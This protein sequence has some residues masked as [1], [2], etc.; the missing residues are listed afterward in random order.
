MNKEMVRE[1]FEYRDDQLYWRSSGKGRSNIS[2]PA[3]VV[4]PRGHR[5]IEVKGK[6]YKAHRLIWLYVNG[7]F[8]DNHIDHID[9]DPSNNRIEN[10]RDVTR[11]ENNK[12][13]RK[14]RTNKSGH[15]GVCWH[16]ASDKWRAH[17]KVDGV[18]KHLGL[19]NVLEDAVAA[20]QAAS[21]KHGFHANHG[22]D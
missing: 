16:K 9:G 4:R 22:R 6:E 14:P 13:K 7:K 5:E 10:L 19:F 1:L 11:Q 21:V 8:P 15:M 2:K 20:R 12:N 18:L 3:G 17:I